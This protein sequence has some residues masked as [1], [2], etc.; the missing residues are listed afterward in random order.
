MSRHKGCKGRHDW[1]DKASWAI[2]NT[3]PP[4]RKITRR[5]CTKCGAV[6]Y[7]SLEWASSPINGWVVTGTSDRSVELDD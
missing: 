6:Q 2:G 4:Y 5:F 7:T 3:L 1:P